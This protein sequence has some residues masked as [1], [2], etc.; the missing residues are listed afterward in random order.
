MNLLQ[1]AESG[2]TVINENLQRIRELCIQAAND[3]NGSVERTAIL[4]EVT[5]R[6]DDMTRIAKGAKFN[7]I[8][9]LDGTSTST[10]LQVGANAVVSTNTIDIAGVLTDS[11]ASTLGVTIAITGGNWTSALIRSYIGQ[12]DLAINDITSR[13][14][15]IGALQNRLESTLDNLTVMNENIQASE[16]RIRD[17]DI[18]KESANMVKNQILQQ[19]SASV[20]TQANQIPT[21]ALSLIRG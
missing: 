13:R 10:L 12:L 18:A 3:T 9:L 1:I 15:N 20:L 5:A 14:S 7:N 19:A 17:L 21:L 11:Q 6:I 8:A 2:L 16:S 4:A